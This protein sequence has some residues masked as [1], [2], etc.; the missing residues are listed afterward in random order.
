MW[1]S[2]DMSVAATDCSSRTWASIIII[3]DIRFCVQTNYHHRIIVKSIWRRCRSIPLR[4]SASPPFLIRSSVDL[5]FDAN[6][7]NWQTC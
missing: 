2:V 7:V 5:T 3:I 6:D 4:F 1:N